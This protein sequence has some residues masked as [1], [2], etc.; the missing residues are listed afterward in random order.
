[1]KISYNWLQDYIKLTL[2]IEQ[3]SELLT[4]LGLE[5]EGIE[6]I[7]SIKGGL[8]G[9]VVGKILKCEQH[10]NADKL[11][12]TTV[13]IGLNKPVQIVCGAPNVAKGQTVPVATIGTILYN[14]EES[15]KIKKS[16]LRGEVSEGM[17]CS[18]NE[19]GL[20]KGNSGIM[21]LENT[22]EIGKPLAEVFDIKTDYIIEIGLTPNRAD[23]MSHYGVARDLRAG[24]LQQDINTELITP[25]VSDF[26]V[27]ER[28]NKIGIEVLDYDLAPRYAGV[29]ISGIKVKES[30]KWLQNRLKAISVQ[31]INNIVDATNYVMHSIGQPLHAYDVAKINGKKIKVQTL[32]EGTKIV[33]LD[34]IERSLHKEDLIICD[35][36]DN[37]LCIA[38]VFGGLK[39]SVTE[40]TNS[41][42]LESAYFNSVSIR[43]TAKRHQLNSDASFRFERGIDPNFVK[44]ALRLVSILIKGIAGGKISSEI[45][46]LYPKRIEGFGLVVSYNYIYKLI[47]DKIPKET[48]IRI[49]TSLD[50]K[51]NSQTEYKLGLTVPP[52]RVDVK[53]EADIV[54]EILRVYGYNNVKIADKVNTSVPS[55][56][57]LDTN[58]IQNIIANQLTAHGFYETM[59][60]SLTKP[61]YSKIPDSINADYNV[62]LLNPLSNDL[63]VMRQSMIFSG[64]EAIIYNINRKK[65]NLKFFEYGNTYHK[66]ANGYEEK[67]HLSLFLTGNKI[68]VNWISSNKKSDFFYLKGIVKSILERLGITNFKTT[69][70]KNDIF[71]EG[72]N[73]QKGKIKLV[74]FGVVAPKITKKFGIKNEVLYADFDWKT[75]LNLLSKDNFNLR[76]IPKYPE[77]KRDLALLI[78]ENVSF[79]EIYN[80]AFQTESKLLKQVD[81][82][83]VYEGDNLPTGKKSYAVSFILQ[84]ESKTLEDKQIDKIM[85]KLQDAFAKHCK[86]ELR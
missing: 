23:A 71:L 15:F 79:K 13:D 7:E 3:I 64:L 53:R 46:D 33:T 49:L 22:L 60:N 31:P 55:F 11:K 2:P 47:G 76:A 4:D 24:L 20:G 70:S 69:P 86:A 56:D 48:I 37:P 58:K 85:Q 16:K 26:H 9:L 66:Y 36:D 72:I 57:K 80:I 10:P 28:T 78:D 74:E 40:K 81:L 25:S 1:M 44:Y 52:F 61:D 30:P 54:E 50:I 27:D 19:I 73:F 59:A 5:V 62:E 32:P 6:K 43:K 38:G 83:D 67:Y 41:I 34:G 63:C 65:P 84:D 8:K 77:V 45:T 18:E 14:D 17:I 68:P 82:F 21:V 35:G 39:S 42:F 29:T 75:I 51:I 12:V